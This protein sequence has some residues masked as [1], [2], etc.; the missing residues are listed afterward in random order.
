MGLFRAKH[1]TA[2]GDRNKGALVPQPYSSGKFEHAP[3]CDS[4]AKRFEMILWNPE[5]FCIL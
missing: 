2:G 4:Q 1:V 5:Y 3:F